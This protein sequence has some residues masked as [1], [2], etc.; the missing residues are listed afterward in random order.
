[1]H[2]T[3]FNN[4]KNKFKKI[5]TSSNLNSKDQS[6]EYLSLNYR[7]HFQSAMQFKH[8]TKMLLEELYYSTNLKKM[9]TSHKKMKL[10]KLKSKVDYIYLQSNSNFD[11]NLNEY[12][13]YYTYDQ[14]ID[15]LKDLEEKFPQYI[16]LK[17]GQK[18]FDLPN[19]GGYCGKNKQKCEHYIV[20]LTDHNITSKR[21]PQVCK[22]IYKKINLI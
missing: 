10:K 13:K 4:L 2:S 9:N 19:P 1:M 21:K 14:I 11:K 16:K 6:N 5:E 15:Q 3:T 17:T 8:Q 12:Y 7:N 22:I 20:F 18:L